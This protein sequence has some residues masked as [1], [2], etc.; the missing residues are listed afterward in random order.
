MKQNLLK[1]VTIVQREISNSN[2]PNQEF[3]DL[4]YIKVF[5]QINWK[6]AAVPDCRNC[7]LNVNV[8]NAGE[9]MFHLHEEFNIER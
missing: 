2:P 5:N 4:M 7:P 1:I 9:F 6:C 3:C 8:P